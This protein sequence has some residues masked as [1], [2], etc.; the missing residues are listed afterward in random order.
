MPVV[1]LEKISSLPK[2]D[3]DG[4]KA[5]TKPSDFVISR[6]SSASSKEAMGK[7]SLA[8]SPKESVVPTKAGGN[9][10]VP[11]DGLNRKLENSPTLGEKEH[12]KSMKK[13]PRESSL[14]CLVCGW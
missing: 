2:P 7:S 12:V 14:P 8:A 1:N 13:M 10:V 6:Q 11:A 4:I 5:S 9:S 3:G